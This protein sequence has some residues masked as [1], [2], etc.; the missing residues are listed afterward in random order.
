MENNAYKTF[1]NFKPVSLKTRF[2][3]TTSGMTPNNFNYFHSNYKKI[4][5]MALSGGTKCETFDQL[6]LAVFMNK[7]LLFLLKTWPFPIKH[8]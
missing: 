7:G 3:K 1:Q 6:I 8:R 5:K 2:F 4:F